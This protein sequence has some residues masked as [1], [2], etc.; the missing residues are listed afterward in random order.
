MKRVASCL[1]L[2]SLFVFGT[3]VSVDA[4]F[5]LFYYLPAK[6]VTTPLI[7][8]IQSP[9][10]NA[11]LNSNLTFLNF[12]VTK[13][14]SWFNNQSEDE[15][16]PING[17][18]NNMPV[19]YMSLGRVRSWYY[20]LD[21]VKS[22]NNS[23]EDLDGDSLVPEQIFNF[24]T[25]LPAADGS[26]NLTIVVQSQ[27]YYRDLGSRIGDDV[28]HKDLISY[29]EPINFT[30]DQILPTVSFNQSYQNTTIIDSK[31]TFG[32]VFNKPASQII[33]S[34]DNQVNQTIDGNSNISINNL[35][36]GVHNLTVYA[37]DKYGVVS[38]PN[39]IFFNVKVPT[40]FPTLTVIIP[41]GIIAVLLIGALW[42]YRRHQKQV[43]KV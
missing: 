14:A 17:Y 41:T 7:I 25:K 27:T 26:H 43:K 1:I 33:Y 10:Q 34:L 4:N 35:S 11:V 31:A 2:L 12:T 37:V 21:G 39:N 3:L 19:V 13:P 38:E 22:Q 42:A 6:P 28:Y 5:I 20:E 40:P 9:N 24:S 23:I 30:V 18:S 29:S 36:N 16:V 15:Y 8:D 32:L